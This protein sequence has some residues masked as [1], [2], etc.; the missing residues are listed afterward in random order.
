MLLERLRQ[1]HFRTA[2]SACKF[3]AVRVLLQ[4]MRIHAYQVVDTQTTAIY[5]Q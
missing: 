1:M 4:N 2:C 5:E 3:V